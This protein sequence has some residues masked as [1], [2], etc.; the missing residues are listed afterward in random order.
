MVPTC[1]LWYVWKKINNRCFEDLKRSLK[2]IFA[3]FFFF[4]FFSYFVSMPVAFVSSLSLSFG[5]F[6][7]RFPLFS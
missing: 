6:L 4:F 3:S 2:G 7:V 5:D 1:L